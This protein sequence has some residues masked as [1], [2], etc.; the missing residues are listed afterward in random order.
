MY[1]TA[2]Q[3]AERAAAERVKAA[4]SLHSR[5]EGD[6]CCDDAFDPWELFPSVYG[7]YESAFDQLAIQVLEDVRDMTHHRT[8][9]AARM[10]REM[11][12]TAEL[13][14]YGTSPRVCFPNQAFKPLIDPL[15]A[16][17]KEYYR[18]TWGE[19]YTPDPED[20]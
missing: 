1:E 13:C 12:C 5:M 18:A 2:V 15:L 6:D 14:D 4:L 19:D 3:A 8:D 17:W 16:K 11:L 9:L 7:S 20:I 10:F